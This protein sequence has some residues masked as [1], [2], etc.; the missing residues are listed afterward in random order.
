MMSHRNVVLFLKLERNVLPE[1]V[2]GSRT[3]LEQKLNCILNDLSMWRFMFAFP[4]L[5]QPFQNVILCYFC[6]HE[7]MNVLLDCFVCD[8]RVKLGQIL[9][10]DSSL[11]HNVLQ[12]NSVCEHNVLSRKLFGE[13]FDILID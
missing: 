5:C 7:C 3:S 10:I 12:L 11:V 6:N 13:N 4:H 9:E 1:Q 8:F 2:T